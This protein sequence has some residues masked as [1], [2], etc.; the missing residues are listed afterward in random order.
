M[1]PSYYL[2]SAKSLF[3]EA[4][5]AM[6]ARGLNQARLEELASLAAS[7]YFVKLTMGVATMLA[8]FVGIAVLMWAC[9]VLFGITGFWKVL[10]HES[11]DTKEKVKTWAEVEVSDK[12]KNSDYTGPRLESPV[13]MPFTEPL[14]KHLLKDERD[15]PLLHVLVSST[16]VL[17]PMAVLVYVLFLHSNFYVACFFGFVV[18]QFVRIRFFTDSML[19]YRHFSS[20]RPLFKIKALNYLS[21]IYLDPIMGIPPVVFLLHHTI[22][23]H[24]ANNGFYDISSTEPYQR[25]SWVAFGNYWFRFQIMAY[26]ELPVFAWKTGR[27]LWFFATITIIG[28]FFYFLQYITDV[29][30]GWAT[31]CVFGIPWIIDHADDGKRNWCQHLFAVQYDSKAPADTFWDLNCGLAYNLVDSLENRQQFNEGY[32]VV[33][34]AYGGVHWST[35]PDM[36]YGHVEKMATYEQDL[37]CITFINSDIWE[38]WAHVA[39]RKLPQLVK[40]KF[41]HIPTAARPNPPT[42]EEVVTELQARLQP[43]DFSKRKAPEKQTQK[44][45]MWQRQA[46]LTKLIVPYLDEAPPSISKNRR[47]AMRRLST[48]LNLATFPFQE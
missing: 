32:H 2:S 45:K 48:D 24:I 5:A 28:G 20:H 10:R 13:K 22:M 36:F 11:V 18:Y 44:R 33:H 37:L 31:F 34:H 1:D 41:V 12:E 39:S 42:I 40:N 23:H 15:L 19:H 46:T 35:I 7:S 47:D 9:I 30:S 21:N 6:N 26:L 3:L 17:I 29:Y 16:C 25:D 4:A 43:L 38:V 27:K 8:M 14:L